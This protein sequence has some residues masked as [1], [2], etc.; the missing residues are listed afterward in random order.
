MAVDLHTHTNASDGSLTPRELVREAVRQ[1]VRVLA[2]T[3]HDSTDGL[4]EALDEATQHPPLELVPG[5]EINT[6]IDKAE[7]HILGYFIDWGAAWFQEVLRGFRE[8]RRG[9]IYRMAERLA[10]LGMPIDPEE[11]FA[12]VQEGSPGRPHVA[13]V[14]VHRGYVGSVGEA[15]D[16]FLK[17]GGPAYVSY[18]KL[19]PEEAVALVR[20]AGGIPVLAHPGFVKQDDL[21]LRLARAGLG[22][23]ECYYAAHTPEQTAAFARLARELGLVATG[24]SD[25]HGPRVTPDSRVGMPQV[26]YEVYEALLAARGAEFPLDKSGRRLL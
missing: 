14:M 12:L 15:F 16:R 24:G 17:H 9:R 3:D 21:I 13:Q 5:I 18:Q 1:G 4:A 26:P 23:V 19:S 7:V 22:G 8:E 25:Y 10:A 11:V 6:E 20:K 2:I